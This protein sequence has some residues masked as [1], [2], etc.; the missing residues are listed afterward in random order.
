MMLLARRTVP[1][2]LLLSLI[3]PACTPKHATGSP[4]PATG[5]TGGNPGGNYVGRPVPGEPGPAVAPTGTDPASSAHFTA[6]THEPHFAPALVAPPVLLTLPRYVNGSSSCFANP[7]PYQPYGYVGQGYGT[8]GGSYSS[9]AG[10]GRSGGSHRYA[11]NPNQATA[12]AAPEAKASAARPSPPPAP[13]AADA[14]RGASEPQKRT[15]GSAMG[16][17]GGGADRERRE[18]AP[19]SPPQPSRDAFGQPIY[20]SNDETMSLSSAQRVIWAIER[21][22]P[23]P[24]EHVRPHELLNYFSFQT[25][26][27]AGDHDFSVLANITELDQSQA[28]L[29]LS[30]QGRPVTRSSRRNVNLAY[31]VDRS[32]SMAA[33]GRME[34][35]KQGLSRSLDELKH[36]DVVHITLFDTGVCQLAE[37]FVVGR[38]NLAELRSSIARIS[39]EGSTNLHDGLTRGYE[40][41]DR[42]YQPGYSNRVVLITDA[43]ANTGVTDEAMIATVGQHYDARRIRLSGIG[44]GTTFNDS[45]LDQLT[46]RGRG[47]Y[48]FLGSPGEVDAVFGS[49]F[50]SLVETIAG[51]VHFRLH[52][53][54][55]LAMATF[56]GE[57]ASVN[58]ERVQSVH[59]FANTAQLFLSDLKLRDAALAPQD[60]LMLTIEYEDP[61]SGQARVEEFAF[62]IGDVRGRAPNLDK[63]SY[64]DAFSRTVRAL[65]DRPLP[66]YTEQRY[67][68]ADDQ[69]G[70]ECRQQKAAASF[71][72]G[73]IQGD[74]EVRRIEQLWDTFCSRYPVAVRPPVTPRP[75]PYRAPNPERHNDYAPPD[76]WPGATSKR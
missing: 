22:A 54:P 25:Q 1:L 4:P 57:E 38:D 43:E 18:M 72:A 46:E 48:V 9:G 68:W 14:W 37:N 51:D 42:A 31:V 66:S 33:E 13:A 17:I 65:S 58:K 40:A 69:A 6:R 67:G 7:E 35:L 47:A 59:Y 55:S 30:I 71:F 74:P 39:P 10:V 32:G 8:S 24:R 34:Y 61:E 16:P 75:L 29:A 11:V 36:G 21:F 70:S 26:P 56:Y 3:L 62:R 76:S 53:P 12:S 5:G 64:V 27:V 45:L 28:R 19:Y 50:V 41:A 20:L 49:R 73:P 15:D 44:V 52:L 60:D 23:I 2:T 63:A